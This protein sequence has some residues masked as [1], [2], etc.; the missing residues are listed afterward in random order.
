MPISDLNYIVCVRY[1]II[2]V[3][4]L[5]IQFCDI[6][7]I[8]YFLRLVFQYLLSPLLDVEFFVDFLRAYWEH[9]MTDES[10]VQSQFESGIEKSIELLLNV[11][12]EL[13]AECDLI[14]GLAYGRVQKLHYNLPI[15][16][17]IE[18]LF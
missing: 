8:Y 13:V 1:L 10:P 5:L 4:H 16:D 2:R 14:F 6:V 17:I 7:I 12:F 15:Y 11:L 18:E 3:T 9:E